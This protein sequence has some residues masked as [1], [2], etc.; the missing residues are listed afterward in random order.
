[1][2]LAHDGPNQIVPQRRQGRLRRLLR[3]LAD[4]M[5]V[6]LLVA[7][8]TYA[9]IGDVTDAIITLAAIVP[10]ATVGWGLEARAEHTL[11]QLRRLTAPTA[12]VW[13]DG[14]HRSIPAEELVA[15]DLVW[16]H[17]GDVVPAD[18]QLVQ[19]TQLLVDESAL[20]GES[21]PAAKAA[22]GQ[23]EE[24][25]MLAGTTV[26]SGRAVARVTATGPAM[27]PSGP[28]SPRSASPRPRCSGRSAAWS[29]PLGWWRRCSVSPW[30]RPSWPG[31]PAGARR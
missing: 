16:L 20:T 28:W 5:V 2:R 6:L 13:R 31:G 12:T 17:E 29:G 9:A 14:R 26:L 30:W 7:A 8:P 19:L 27:G 11:E 22:S 1:V 25:M 21:L 15:G 4:P 10:I 18:G 23:G 24:A 3:P